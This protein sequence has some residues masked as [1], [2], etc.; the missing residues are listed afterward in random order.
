MC[1]SQTSCRTFRRSGIPC[2]NVGGSFPISSLRTDNGVDRRSTCACGAGDALNST[3][4]Q[5]SAL[6]FQIIIISPTNCRLRRTEKS[7][8]GPEIVFSKRCN[9]S[10]YFSLV[11]TDYKHCFLRLT[12]LLPVMR[13]MEQLHLYHFHGLCGDKSALPLRGRWKT[14]SW[15]SSTVITTGRPARS[16]P[17]G[18]NRRL[19]NENALPLDETE[20]PLT[21]AWQSQTLG[22]HWIFCRNIPVALELYV[23]ATCSRERRGSSTSQRSAAQWRQRWIYLS[24]ETAVATRQVVTN[25]NPTVRENISSR[26]AITC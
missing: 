5:P 13:S 2:C 23:L 24:G 4:A 26:Q 6:R 15:Y 21:R 16:L 3:A 8:C 22:K 1:L 7:E 12:T 18:S 9:T 25:D 14:S 11:L 17:N 10:I 19:S 20:S